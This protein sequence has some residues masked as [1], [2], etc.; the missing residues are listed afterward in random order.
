MLSLRSNT[1]R[2]ST[3]Q[4]RH[5]YRSESRGGH[6]ILQTGG[7]SYK[8]QLVARRCNVQTLQGNISLC[9]ASVQPTLTW[10]VISSLSCK[11]RRSL[12]NFRGTSARCLPQ[13]CPQPVSHT[14]NSSTT[15]PCTGTLSSSPLSL[16]RR[17]VA[18]LSTSST[19]LSSNTS[20]PASRSRQRCGTSLL[21]SPSTPSSSPARART[22]LSP[23]AASSQGSSLPLRTQPNN[24]PLS[25]R[26]L[27]LW[28]RSSSLSPMLRPPSGTS[29]A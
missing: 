7:D 27:C 4:N 13:I 17:F 8:L 1:Y 28:P 29:T 9:S 16:T 26:L 19:T 18:F 21:T 23:R 14:T 15:S 20:R 5:L 22:T 24:S 2:P 10:T 12:Q 6:L 3:S 11:T 25:R